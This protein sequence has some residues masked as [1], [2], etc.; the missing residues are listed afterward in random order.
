MGFLVKQL[1]P[2]DGI[3]EAFYELHRKTNPSKSQFAE[4]AL[5]FAEMSKARSLSEQ[6]SKA[7][8]GL[9]QESIPLEIQN[10][11]KDF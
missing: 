4:E 8:A 10:E 2:Y 1:S 6:L 5:K 7:R 3:I 9:I 11:D